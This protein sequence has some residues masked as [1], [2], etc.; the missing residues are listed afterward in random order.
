MSRTRSPSNGSRTTRDAFW[1]QMSALR[2]RLSVS[3]VVRRCARRAAEPVAVRAAGDGVDAVG[4][5]GCV[6]PSR[7]LATNAPRSTNWSNDGDVGAVA[8]R[9]VRDAEGGGQVEDVVDAVL[10]H[11]LV[12]LLGVDVGL[13]G[14]GELRLLV[15]PLVV[16][17]HGAQVEPLLRGATSERRPGRRRAVATPGMVSRRRVAERSAQHVDERHRIVS[18]TEDLRLEHR[19]VDELAGPSHRPSCHAAAITRP[20]SHSPICPPTNSGARSCAPRPSPT[21]PPDHACRVNS[22]AGSVAHGPSR[23]NGVIDVTVRCGMTLRPVLAGENSSSAGDRRARATTPRRP[24]SPASRATGSTSSSFAGIDDDA[25][26]RARQ[27]AEQ[28][29]VVAGLDVGSRCRPPAQ[30]IAFGRLDFD[31]LG[32]AV[33]EQLRAVGAG[34]P[35]GQ[36]DDGVAVERRLHCVMSWSSSRFDLLSRNSGGNF[37]SLSLTESARPASIAS[38]S[39]KSPASGRTVPPIDSNIAAQQAAHV[40]AL[41]LLHHLE[42]HLLLKHGV[43]GAV[44]RARQR[45]LLDLGLELVA[46][47]DLVEEVARQH[48]RGGERPPGEHHLLELAQPHRQHPGPHPRSPAVVAERRVAEKRVV[49]GDHE[50]GVGALVEVPAVAVALGLDDADLL[51]LLQRPVARRSVGVPLAHRRAVAEGAFRRIRDVGVLATA[52]RRSRASSS[53]SM[54]SGRSAPLPRSSPTPRITTTLTSSSTV[55]PR[56]RSA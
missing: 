15:D 21:T 39:M 27:E 12:D 52:T 53:P 51:E 23:P 16:A 40:L 10:A 26:L 44:T 36:V 49:R 7:G 9:R 4:R 38:P 3:A 46:R 25:V 50:V 54:N 18:E 6:N 29:A 28:R 31:D 8:D 24:R 30:R 11:P 19:Q 1:A 33:G 37:A 22:V 32:A 55:A 2:A 35:D 47:D 45:V 43:D 56:S 48:L 20:A 42:E 17:D 14:D 34:D 13:L 5:P 41:E